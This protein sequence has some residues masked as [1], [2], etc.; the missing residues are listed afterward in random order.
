MAD[1]IFRFWVFLQPQRIVNR[2]RGSSI[3]GGQ[4]VAHP[5]TTQNEK[6]VFTMNTK[7]PLKTRC[8]ERSYL[9]EWS[10]DPP[11]IMPTDPSSSF[12]TASLGV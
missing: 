5:T 11:N 7:R 1:S 12:S 3:I 4:L 9:E 10:S 2:L 6:M 8:I